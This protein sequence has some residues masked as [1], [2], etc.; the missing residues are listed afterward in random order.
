MSH[1]A[2]WAWDSMVHG[3][4]QKMTD[5][6]YFQNLR[7]TKVFHKLFVVTATGGFQISI[8]IHFLVALQQE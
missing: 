1:I 5:F 4:P 3:L 2:Q 7:E 6:Q 8:Y